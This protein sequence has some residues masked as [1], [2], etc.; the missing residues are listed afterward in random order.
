MT[1]LTHLLQTGF[2]KLQNFNNTLYLT[3]FTYIY[4]LKSDCSP[5]CRS[6][7]DAENLEK[8]ALSRGETL[9]TEARFDS[10]CITP[11]TEFMVRLHTQLQYFVVNK[12]SNDKL[13]QGVKVYLSGHEVSP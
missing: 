5:L 7:K 11:G 1:I 6:A 12:V 2:W 4:S 8:Q 9:P 3:L 13:W 10:N